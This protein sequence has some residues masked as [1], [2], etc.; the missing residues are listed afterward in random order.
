[1]SEFWRRI[2]VLLHRDRFDRDLAEEM[3]N[4][5]EM[6]ADENQQNGMPERDARLAAQSRFGNTTL[7]RETSTDIWGWGPFDRLARDLRYAARTLRANPGFA[8]VAIFSLALGIGANTAIFTVA[9]A[10]LLRPLPVRNPEQLIIAF[11]TTD[12]G[13]KGLWKQNSNDKADTKTGRRW[14]NTFP[15]GA[16]RE[17]RNKVSDTVEMFAFFSPGRMSASDSSGT[18]P[19]RVMLVSGNFF[20]AAGVPLTLGRGLTNDD[21]QHAAN[22]I[23]VTSSFWE[24][25]LNRDAAILGKT[26]RLNGAPMT[27]V[28]VTAAGFRGI[29]A[30]GFDGAMDVFASLGALVTIAPLEVRAGRK[31]KAAPDYWWIQMMGRLKPGVTM[32]MAS[33]RLTAVFRGFLAGSGITELQ[34]AKNPRILVSRGD[35]GLNDLREKIEQPLFILLVVVA[36]VLL[37]ACVNLAGLQVARAA[38]RRREIAVRLSLGASRWRLVRQLLMESLLLSAFGAIGGGLLAVW[39]APL[40]ARLLT[41]GRQFDEVWLDLSPDYRIL[42]FTLA[43]VVMTALVFGLTPAIRATRVD[44]AP[45]LKGSTQT[46]ARG[47]PL[48][49]GKVLIAGQAALSL[50]LLAGS[51]LFLRTLW[52]LYDQDV[53]FRRD[54]LLLFRLD[55]GQFRLE[56]PQ[57]GPL[58]DSVL[59]SMAGIPGVRSVASMSHIPVGGWRNSTVLYSADTDW[60]PIDL[61]MNTVSPGYFDTLG[62]PILAGR[63]FTPGDLG[64]AQTLAVLNESAAHALCGNHIAVGQILKRQWSNSLTPVE[65]IGVVRDAKFASLRE[66]MQPTVFFL[67]PSTY[68]FTGRAFAVRTASDPLPLLGAIR[69]AIANINRD[70]VMLDVNTQIGLMQE[71]LYRERL[72]ATLLTA[73]GVFALLLA[74]IGLHGVTAYSTARRTAEIGLR[75]ALGAGRANVIGLVVRQVLRPV[76]IGSVVGLIAASMATRWIE[77]MLFGVNRLDPGSMAAAFTVLIGVAVTAALVPAWRAA[78]VDP[79]TALR[80]D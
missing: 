35:R 14:Y 72:F 46:L 80:A 16:L 11:S 63:G 71:S 9:N 31:S 68:P 48:G 34:Q 60:R 67:Y 59:R 1:M 3:R 53:G 57:T 4:H 54:R 39:G 15:V 7:L 26:L 65:V 40:I 50:V 51:G 28:G 36:V 78:K 33:E 70:L 79:V 30:G 49:L 2:L 45:G 21:D 66:P 5:L 69:G 77:S 20:E 18:R 10:V 12:T 23:V 73:F 44:I 76:I 52:N 62:M 19:A 75:M 22:T 8:A 58:F 64:S 74:A 24:S 37:L 55:A 25:A 38:A 42:T 32:H 6:E 56:S 47:G 29:S 17:F 27:V 43:A 41:L 13:I 61:L